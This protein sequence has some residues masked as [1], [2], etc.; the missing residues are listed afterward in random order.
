[1][2]QYIIDF[3]KKWTFKSEIIKMMKENG[4][5]TTELEDVTENKKTFFGGIGTVTV[6]KQERWTPKEW[7]TFL[8]SKGFWIDSYTSSESRSQA[9][10]YLTNI[11]IL[12]YIK[13]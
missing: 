11:V 12:H 8:I 4:I 7:L 1:M 2:K 13:N 9:G 6:D 5:N 10:T 3:E